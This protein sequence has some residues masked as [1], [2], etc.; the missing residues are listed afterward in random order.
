MKLCYGP[1][2]A[3]GIVNAL[4]LA[5]G[6]LSITL[7]GRN[8]GM[9]EDWSMIPAMTGNE[10][11]LLNWLW[12]QNNEHRLPIQRLIFLGLLKATGDF[13]SGM[14]LSQLLL[15]FLATALAWSAAQ[16]RGGQSRWSDLLFPLAILHLGH[17]ENLVWGWQIQFVWSTALVGLLLAIVAARPGAMSARAGWLAAFLLVLLPISG[18]N[19]IVVAAPMAL[20][21]A[22]HGATKLRFDPDPA[23]RRQGIA[24]L[25]AAALSIALIGVYFIGY[26]SPPWSPPPPTSEQFL[27]AATTYFA[28]AL[29]PAARSESLLAAAFV[30]LV[31]G[32][33]GLLAFRTLL[34]GDPN[35]RLRAGGLT[36]IIGAGIVLGIAIAWGRGAAGYRMPDRYAL[37]SALTLLSSVY[38]WELYALQRVA[39]GLSA[40]LAI[41]FILLLPFN[42]R[43]GF[44]WRDWYV[45]G[46]RRVEADIGSGV[47]IPEMAHRHHPFLMH[48]SEDRLREGMLMLSNGGI[49]PFAKAAPN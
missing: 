4:L 11:D 31:I 5:A 41:L 8:I 9:A 10:P 6:L 37:F 25:V 28:Y 46:M 16:A 13:R 17:W 45:D 26:V 20:W 30:V 32:L 49:G 34:T 42:V 15:A 29:G 24:L 12:S 3:I 21:L 7:W 38:A 27:R 36:L 43:S 47:P 44:E 19:G 40:G 14:V 33:G 23:T 2:R 18:A 1:P 48:W 39:R 22:A 35:E